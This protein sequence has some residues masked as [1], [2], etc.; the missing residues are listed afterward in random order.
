MLRSNIS[1]DCLFCR[2][3]ARHVPATIVAE[4]PGLMAFADLH[5]Q[6]PTHLLII[7]T[8]HLATLSDMTEAHATLLGQAL[9]FASRLATQRQ[10]APSGYRVVINCGPQAGQSVWHLHLHLLGGRAMGWP[11]G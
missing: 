9:H 5:P 4:E 2:I 8:E 7:P 6:A 10:L 11:P 3:A 1:D